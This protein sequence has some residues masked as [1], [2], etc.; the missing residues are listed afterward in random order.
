MPAFAAAGIVW[1]TKDLLSKE[2]TAPSSTLTAQPSIVD[3]AHLPTP[4]QL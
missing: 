2:Q 1:S 3:W 4:V